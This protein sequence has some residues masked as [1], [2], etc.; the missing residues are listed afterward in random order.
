MK[1]KKLI[2]IEEDIARRFK[3]VVAFQGKAMSPIIEKLINDYIIINE[4][5]IEN[6]FNRRIEL[7]RVDKENQKEIDSITPED[8]IEMERQ[9][10]IFARRGTPEETEEDREFY[11]SLI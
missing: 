1:I 10:K 3:G 9:H 11:A 7:K 6:E 8:K 5:I 4:P 2:Y